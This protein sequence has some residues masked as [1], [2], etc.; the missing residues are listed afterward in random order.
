MAR[1]D[2][3]IVGAYL[4]TIRSPQS[5]MSTLAI[6]FV[7]QSFVELPTCHSTGR[8]SGPSPSEPSR[9]LSP[10]GAL[11]GSDAALHNG[12]AAGLEWGPLGTDH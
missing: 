2:Q 12:T 6:G 10:G 7:S 9:D 1:R 8:M 11:H 4:V 5:L 3:G